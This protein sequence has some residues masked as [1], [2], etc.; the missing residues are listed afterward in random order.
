MRRDSVLLILD[1]A[2]NGSVGAHGYHPTRTTF[3]K[4]RSV[5]M[6]T[7]PP[8]TRGWI[9]NT[10][11]A[12][13]DRMSRVVVDAR[14]VA[15][16]PHSLPNPGRMTMSRRLNPPRAGRTVMAVGALTATALEA[17]RLKRSWSLAFRFGRRTRLAHRGRPQPA[18]LVHVGGQLRRSSSCRIAPKK[19]TA[20]TG[21][22]S[23]L[24]ITLPELDARQ[25]HRAK[26]AIFQ[27]ADKST[28]GHRRLR[29]DSE[30]R[31]DEIPRSASVQSIM[32][33]RLTRLWS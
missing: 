32:R 16:Y 6:L 4:E 5:E 8:T 9:G 29:C 10:I 17:S 22:N 33:T 25:F 26:P 2:R 21:S 12:C 27:A 24:R 30:A 11:L 15:A 3:A 31:A 7:P 20:S 1:R 18:P 28:E 23:F 13:S 14:F 19:P